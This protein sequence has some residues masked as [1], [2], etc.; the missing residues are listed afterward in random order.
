MRRVCRALCCCFS[1]TQDCGHDHC[2]GSPA[3]SSVVPVWL[4][5]RTLRTCNLLSGPKRPRRILVVQHVEEKAGDQGC[6]TGGPREGFPEKWHQ[7]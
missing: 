4:R 2:L 3:K 6:A 5:S 7:S 1:W